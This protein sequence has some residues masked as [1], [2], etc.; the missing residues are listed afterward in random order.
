MVGRWPRHAAAEALRRR[1]EAGGAARDAD[2]AVGDESGRAVTTAQKSEA[3]LCAAR[4]LRVLCE[5][6]VDA[7]NGDAIDRH[8][9]DVIVPSLKQRAEII[10]RRKR[11]TTP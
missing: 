1:G 10:A 6:R 5:R 11:R 3:W 2:R 7:G 8:I 9:L 4:M